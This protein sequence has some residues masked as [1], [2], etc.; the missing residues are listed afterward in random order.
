MT[1]LIFLTVISPLPSCLLVFSFFVQ[2]CVIDTGYH[3]GHVDLPRIHL[4][5]VDGFSLYK[6]IAWNN[7]RDGHGTHCAE[8]SEPLAA[9]RWALPPSI[10]TIVLRVLHQ[11]GTEQQKEQFVG[12]RLGLPRLLSRTGSPC[13]HHVPEGYHFQLQSECSQPKS[14]RGGNV[15][16]C[17]GGEQGEQREFVSR[18]FSV[19]D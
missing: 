2:V 6:G 18:V 17:R 7:N 12:K 9:T 1:R 8:S 15:P 4:H 13:G 10:Q 11:E 16:C 3:Y 5:G 14:V 19:G